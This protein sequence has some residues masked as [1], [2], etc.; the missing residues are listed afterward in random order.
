VAS[1]RSLDILVLVDVLID[2]PEGQ[3]Y[4]ELL[5][6]EEWKNEAHILKA[7]RALGHRPRIFGVRDDVLPLVRELTERK[8]DLVFNLCEGF[9]GD[10]RFEPHLVDLLELLGVRYTGAGPT[11]LRVCKD[12]GMAKK[13]LAFHHIRVPRFVTSRRVQPISSLP[14]FS[15]PA[16]IK[17]L[18]LEASEGIAQGSLADT[19]R[20]ALERV[21]F[22]H[23]KHEA[24]AIVEEYVEGR[25]LYVGVLGNERLTVFPPREL[26]FRK[27]PEGEP[28]FAT[29]KAK[30]DDAYRK[31]WGIDTGPAA[32]IERPV[33]R[34]L[35]EVC[36]KV[37]RYFQL[38]GYARIDLRLTPRGE[39]VFLEANPNPTI[40]A[41]E[42]FALSAKAGGLSF[43][44]L[45]AR[46]VT[47]GGTEPKG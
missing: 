35:T 30:W 8:P 20:D 9:G 47:L 28:K 12:K 5:R 42:D 45:V 32:A 10:R 44:E 37:Y 6:T 46:I 39:V 25:E 11:A 38:R 33:M 21:R 24:D 19:E 4:S 15:Y 40:A 36:K 22:L 13:I 31:R 41:D 17:P 29:F 14:G 23:D 34:Q 27:V 2:P 43:D 18:D 16:F 26:F 1:A 3:D 7:L